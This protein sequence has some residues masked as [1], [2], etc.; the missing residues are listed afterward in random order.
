LA[1]EE[2]AKIDFFSAETDAAA[3]VDD[4]D[5]VVVAGSGYERLDSACG[6]WKR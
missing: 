5:L 6:C 3:T 1:G 4:D 2:R